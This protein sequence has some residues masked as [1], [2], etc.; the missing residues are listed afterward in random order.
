MSAGVHQ[1]EEV[2]QGILLA[3]EDRTAGIVDVKKVSSQA[4]EGVGTVTLELVTGADRGRVLQD[5]KNEVDRIIT[6]PAEGSR[7]PMRA[8]LRR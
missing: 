6:F 8:C 7:W 5:V 3:V 1:A 4:L 2:E